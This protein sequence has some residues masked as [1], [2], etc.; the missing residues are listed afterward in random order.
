MRRT[1]SLLAVGSL[2]AVATVL[3]YLGPLNGTH[4]PVEAIG[5]ATRPYVLSTPLFEPKASTN[6][7]LVFASMEDI[8]LSLNVRRYNAVGGL[9]S[10]TNLTLGAKSSIIAFA[11]ANNGAEM[12]VEIW[13]PSP[14]FTMEL[15]YTDGSNALQK[16]PYGDMRQPS[17][18]GLAF[19]PM[20]P[21]RLCNTLDGQGTACQGQTLAA[22]GTLTVTAA[23][24]AGIPL[25]AK[26]VAFTAQVL[27][28]TGSTS[29]LTFWPA[30]STRP[31]TSQI[32]FKQGD[33]LSNFVVVKLGSG[34]AFSVF[35]KNGNT[36]VI[37]DVAGYYV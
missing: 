27:N 14:H 25:A 4:Q 3:T 17:S 15:T 12:H 28:T 23:G 5:S 11:G 6:S 13:S 19:S 20:T 30:G 21:A 9:L 34:G 1:S 22:N 7:T 35:N 8:S 31:A 32:T 2:L 18:P 16:I 10:S 33:K 24:A 36:D 29:Y 26:A 37:V